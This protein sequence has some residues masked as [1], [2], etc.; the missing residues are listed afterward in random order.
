MPQAARKN[1]SPNGSHRLPSHVRGYDYWWR[2]NSKAWL[3]QEIAETVD[4]WC[5][6][7]GRRPATVVDHV[8]PPSSVYEYGTPE[9]IRMFRDMSNWQPAC[10]PCNDKKGGR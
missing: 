1:R 2:K 8:I 10:K 3:K 5:R 9:F 4:P 7:C 6:L